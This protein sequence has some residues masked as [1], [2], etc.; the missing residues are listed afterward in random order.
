MDPSLR[1]V[2]SETETEDGAKETGVPPWLQRPVLVQFPVPSGLSD[3]VEWLGM[4][5]TNGQIWVR[6]PDAV[7]KLV[8]AIGWENC[9]TS[10]HPDPGVD[11]TLPPS[12]RFLPGEGVGKR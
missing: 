11:R 8:K 12:M 3:G 1:A 7:D 10:H 5:K 6:D 4:P 2:D 9:R